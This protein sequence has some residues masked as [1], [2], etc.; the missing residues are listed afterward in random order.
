[1]WQLIWAFL[2]RILGPL[3]KRV[4]I[5]LGIGTVTYVGLDAAF[6]AA[7]NYIIGYYGQMSGD[8]LQVV[9]LAGFGAAI[10]IILGAIAARI[11]LISLSKLTKLS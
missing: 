9:S 10:G 11:A 8:V 5:A 7:K 1:M 6:D 3:A 2:V 4:L